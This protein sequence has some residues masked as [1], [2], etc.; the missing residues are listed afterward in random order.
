MADDNN[1]NGLH[2]V[3]NS[4]NA[5]KLK[6]SFSGSKPTQDCFEDAVSALFCKH[7]LPGS[8]IP[9]EVGYNLGN[10]ASKLTSALLK[11]QNILGRFTTTTL[12]L[13]EVLRSWFTSQSSMD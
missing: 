7:R 9:N 3:A 4:D 8:H 5:L 10:I 11:A 2:C 12:Q 1:S 13:V 6:I